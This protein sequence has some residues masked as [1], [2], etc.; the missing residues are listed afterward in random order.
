MK[1]VIM[2][3]LSKTL[4]MD[5]ES[6]SEKLFK[7]SEDGQLTDEINDNALSELLSFDAARIQKLRESTPKREELEN[8]YKRGQKEAL[9]ELETKLK[10][11][12]D[13]TEDL[14]GTSLVDSI[15][16]KV[17][18]VKL[19]D[20]KVKMHPLV[21]DLQEKLTRQVD[22]TKREYEARIEALETGYKRKE[23]F[24]AVNAKIKEIFDSARPILPTDPSKAAIARDEFT[25]RFK[26]YDYEILENG[27]ILPVSNGKRLEDAHGNPIYLDQLVK[28]QVVRRFDI[29]QQTDKGGGGNKNDP[30]PA[31][32]FKIPKTFEEYENAIYQAKTSDERIAI[33]QAWEQSQKAAV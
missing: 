4:N 11:K 1:E 16:G 29:Q 23:T 28:D 7:K 31:N 18:S 8:Q 6:I 32:G 27:R 17:Q 5:S 25:E 10:K 2:S 3:F 22:E 15:V 24:G 9:L 20:E 13:V 33:N 26:D 12:Y 19:D 14:T 21:L 30:N